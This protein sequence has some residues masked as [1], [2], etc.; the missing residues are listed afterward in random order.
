MQVSTLT[1]C[2]SFEQD[3]KNCSSPQTDICINSGSGGGLPFAEDES[4][5]DDDDHST[6]GCDGTY[7]VSES[8]SK[9]LSVFFSLSLRH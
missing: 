2:I 4:D 8:I 1:I 3:N 7:L 9:P 6:V 5:D